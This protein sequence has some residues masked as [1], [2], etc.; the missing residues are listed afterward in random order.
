MSGAEN[1]MCGYARSEMLLSALT[2]K[3]LAARRHNFAR[4]GFVFPNIYLYFCVRNDGGWH[5]LSCVINSSIVERYGT[6]NLMVKCWCFAA[7]IQ[8]SRI[9]ECVS[10]LRAWFASKRAV[11]VRCVSVSTLVSFNV[12]TTW[13]YF[14]VLTR[15]VRLVAES[16]GSA[17]PLWFV[18]YCVCVSVL[19]LPVSVSKDVAGGVGLLIIALVMS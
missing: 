15:R 18:R 9:L 5:G 11:S 8:S 14:V 16:D 6:R 19:N 1:S 12:E 13:R 4:V 7:A 17:A 2:Q 3:S 10:A